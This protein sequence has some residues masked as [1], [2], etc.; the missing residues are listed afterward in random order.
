M[1]HFNKK[2]RNAFKPPEL[3]EI[4]CDFSCV[5]ESGCI[6]FGHNNIICRTH[7]VIYGDHNRILGGDNKIVGNHNKI[8]GPECD[9]NGFF[10]MLIFASSVINISGSCT[11]ESKHGFKTTIGI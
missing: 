2:R 8:H 4:Y 7:C 5:R 3:K 9:I 11:I 10:N 1:K 6:I